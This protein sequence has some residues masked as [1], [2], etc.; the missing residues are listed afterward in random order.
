MSVVL[1]LLSLLLVV[2]NARIDCGNTVKLEVDIDNVQSHG[3]SYKKATVKKSVPA[4]VVF[5][6]IADRRP[7]EIESIDWM[8]NNVS[9]NIGDSDNQD[10]YYIVEKVN[11]GFTVTLHIKMPTSRVAGTWVLTVIAK[12]NSKHIGVCYVSSPPVIRSRFG[13]VR[14]HEGNPLSVLC[15]IDGFP[16]AKK[17]VWE[18]LV[19]NENDPTRNKLV[20]VTNAIF[21]P[22]EG[23]K[24]AIM[25]WT[26]ASN[27]TGFYMCTA[28]SDLGT[29][30]LLLEVRIKSKLA[31]LWPFIGILAELVV[32]GIIILIYERAQAKRRRDEEDR[33]TLLKQNPKS[34]QM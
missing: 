34:D 12:D 3:I 6:V 5:N 33:N 1:G 8:Y 7:I 16:E 13:P 18:R 19:E 26:D 31:P 30:S 10:I 11:S 21:K 9:I 27:A 23:T 14:G 32:L 28:K 15:E 29:D 4:N 22:H 17:V 20:P 2:V 25:E 24:D